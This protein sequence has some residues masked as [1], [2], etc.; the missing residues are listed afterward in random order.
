MFGVQKSFGSKKFRV[1]KMLAKK[2]GSDTVIARQPRKCSVFKFDLLEIAI[3]LSIFSF[4]CFICLAVIYVL[5]G[6]CQL[7]HTP[8]I[9]R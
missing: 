1:Q 9:L 5:K 8:H 7:N 4:L 2:V 3:A 6:G